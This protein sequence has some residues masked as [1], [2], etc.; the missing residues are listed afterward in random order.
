MHGRIALRAQ[1]HCRL[2]TQELIALTRDFSIKRGITGVL[3]AAVLFGVY[4]YV[5]SRFSGSVV[6]KLPFYA[7]AFMHGLTHMGIEGKDF[8][9]CSAAFFYVLCEFVCAA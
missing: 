1:R 7:P 8:L 9:D 5:N 4:R 6:A 3:T 2:I